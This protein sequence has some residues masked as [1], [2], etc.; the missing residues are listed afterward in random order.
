MCVLKL[1]PVQDLKSPW[2]S[3]ESSTK[4]L[5]QIRDEQYQIITTAMD[6]RFPPQCGEYDTAWRC[7][8]GNVLPVYQ[9][10]RLECLMKSTSS[11]DRNSTMIRDL[12]HS[13]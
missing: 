13:F 4:D 9:N 7:I 3:H 11:W 1:I 8:E 5:D 2:Q 6:W 12:T 10:V